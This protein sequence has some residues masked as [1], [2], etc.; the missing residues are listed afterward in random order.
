M[1][2]K[3]SKIGASG[4]ERWWQCPGSVALSE[5]VPK[6]PPSQAA[7]QGTAAHWLAEHCFK[8]NYKPEVYFDRELGHPEE[9]VDPFYVDEDMVDAVQLYL[10]TIQGVI[11]K[12]PNTKYRGGVEKPC[13]HDFHAIE[14][15]VALTHM[16]P[17]AFGTADF[18]HYS[19]LNKELTV[20][21]F[22]YGAG[23]PVDVINNKQL[24]YYALGA[25]W[26]LA[27]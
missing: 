11:A 23:I 8:K 5:N 1:S 19:R 4:C 12:S 13:P 15:K 27:N 6:V 18:V 16:D 10:D 7:L 24:L 25:Y 21:D 17:G 14:A 9:G 2:E 3:H 26:T 20:V 22:K